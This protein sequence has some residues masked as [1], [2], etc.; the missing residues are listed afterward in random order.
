MI[1]TSAEPATLPE[2]KLPLNL[3]TATHYAGIEPAYT[4][5]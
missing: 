5:N 3:Y 1:V 2:I 4:V